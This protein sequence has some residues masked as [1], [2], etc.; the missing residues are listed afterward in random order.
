MKSC[1]KFTVEA[2]AF[3]GEQS[4]PY[5]GNPLCSSLS[6]FVDSSLM[7]SSKISHSLFCAQLATGH[8]QHNTDV[9]LALSTTK[10]KNNQ[11]IQVTE[12]TK[13]LPLFQLGI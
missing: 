11:W 7:G 13:L 8:G 2:A 3:S 12:K 5:Q 6:F 4:N 10:Q 1:P 9:S